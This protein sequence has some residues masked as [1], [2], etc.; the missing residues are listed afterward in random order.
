MQIPKEYSQFKDKKALFVVTGVNEAVFYI[1]ADGVMN[2][3]QRIKI[4][5]PHYSDREG[6]FKI[7]RGGQTISSGAAYEENKEKLW[8]D[9]RKEFQ[10]A[11]G[12]ILDL[13]LPNT[14]YLYTPAYMA[15]RMREEF[16]PKQQAVIRRVFRGNFFDAH[17]TKILAKLKATQSA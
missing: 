2:E 8:Q 15:V 17:P 10:K 13:S 16:S 6:H 1:A 9:F 3:V 12:S 4:E 11:L 7:R 5:K 14:I